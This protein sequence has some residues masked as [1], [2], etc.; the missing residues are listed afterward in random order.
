MK[1]FFFL[2]GARPQII[3]FAALYP[4][5]KKH[6][7]SFVLVHSGQHYDAEL[8][9]NFFHEFAIDS[10]DYNLRVG[11]ST[12]AEQTAS[13]MISLA[14]VVEK[15]KPDYGV[16]FGDTNTTLAGALV[17]SKMDIPFIHIEAGLR[18]F[19]KKMPE[20]INRIITDRLSSIFFAPSL[21]ARQNLLKEGITQNV[22]VTGDLHYDLFKR[23]EKHLEKI[24]FNSSFGD[25]FVFLTLHREENT[26]S[27]EFVNAL[28]N[29]LERQ[30][31]HVVFPCHPRTYNLLKRTGFK[32][33]HIFP[34]TSYLQTL[35]FI[36]KSFMVITDSGG[37][38]KEAFY[39]RKPV[40]IMRNETEWEE[41]VELG[42][43]KLAAN[44]IEKITELVQNPWE[45]PSFKEVYGDGNAGHKMVGI[46]KE[47]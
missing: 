13:I 4:H 12:H 28:L 45:T 1:K 10:P 16:V 6:R 33:I 24:Q 41:I 40:I 44:N 11:S 32:Y 18:S 27:P 19:N 8:S 30:R 31:I 2:V 39:L 9:E 7:I 17:F 42:F 38:Q 35:F 5:L 20:E 22:Y 14:K 15:V 43:G 36:K 29:E 25:R 34:P 26:K 47:L 3:K 37:V 46:M 21:K 23:M